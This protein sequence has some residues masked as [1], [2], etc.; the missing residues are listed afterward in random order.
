MD[1]RALRMVFL[2]V[3]QYCPLSMIPPIPQIR[4]SFIYHAVYPKQLTA[5]IT[6][7][8]ADPGGCAI[9]DVGLLLLY[10]WG[11]RVRT[12]LRAWMF[13]SCVCCVG[14]GLCHGLITS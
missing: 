11:L 12:P 13:I 10:F 6:H 1:K 2:R 5:S 3:I 4:I 7:F 9:Y 14:S 8:S